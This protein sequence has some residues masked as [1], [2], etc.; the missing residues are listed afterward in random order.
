MSTVDVQRTLNKKGNTDILGKISSSTA[1]K[2][3]AQ[4]NISTSDGRDLARINAIKIHA[5]T[6]VYTVSLVNTH[7][8]KD[9]LSNPTVYD[10]NNHLNADYNGQTFVSSLEKKFCTDNHQVQF[11]EIFLDYYCY[12]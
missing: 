2:C 3:V 11:Q 5:D 6:R 12:I 1:K 4:K 8:T 10:N 9:S 7:P